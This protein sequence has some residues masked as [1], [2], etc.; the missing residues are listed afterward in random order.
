MFEAEC[1]AVGRPGLLLPL[2]TGVGGVDSVGP[3]LHL[4]D[5]SRQVRGIR[6]LETLFDEG[7]DGAWQRLGDTDAPEASAFRDSV[8]AFLAESG[9]RGPDEYDIYAD[10][11]ETKPDL[12]LAHIDRLRR[13]GD[14]DAPAAK[15]QRLQQER[16]A[17]VAQMRALLADDP[18]RLRTFD[19]ALR[20]AHRYMQYRERYKTDVIRPLHEARMALR[21]LGARAADAGA[22]H[23][24]HD[25]MMLLDSE[26]DPFLE[27]GTSMATLLAERHDEY[28]RLAK[29]QPPFF[30]VDGAFAPQRWP[31]RSDA[32][33]VD[34]AVKGEVLRGDPGCPGVGTG[35]AR[36]FT[37]A[38]DASELAPGDVL[39]APYTDPA[40]TPLFV[41]ASAVVVDT[42]ARNSHAVIICRELGTP[43]VVS[44]TGATAR[45]REGARIQVD[46][47]AGTITIL[48]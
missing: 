34:K 1:D 33:D 32:P 30:L 40:W 7:V 9:S 15:H 21:V 43:C 41:G 16:A 8:V 24:A 19:S 6:V 46:G 31:E 10:V 2:I 44:A 18:D 23:D 29:R 37:S 17:A 22:L 11:W 38:S 13:F 48:D 26:L 45:I 36:V 12:A 4:W 47:S 35:F 20:S 42:G 28:R 39:V 25:V 5:L 14:E 27:A 3:S